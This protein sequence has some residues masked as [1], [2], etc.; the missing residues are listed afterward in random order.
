MRR[1]EHSLQR[2]LKG[3]CVVMTGYEGRGVGGQCHC[4]GD[5]TGPLVVWD[6]VLY[7][8]T[9]CSNVVRHGS[10]TLVLST[11]R[12]YISTLPRGDLSGGAVDEAETG[13]SLV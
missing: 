6:T 13:M 4:Q 1:E 2:S 9:T 7:V 5:L 8:D 11:T 3:T 10:K 12:P